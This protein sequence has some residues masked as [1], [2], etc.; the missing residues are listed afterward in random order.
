MLALGVWAGGRGM[1]GGSCFR[2]ALYS[3]LVTSFDNHS[4]PLNLCE[5]TE[6]CAVSASTAHGPENMAITRISVFYA[7][8]ESYAFF[9]AYRFRLMPSPSL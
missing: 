2:F 7:G 6:P 9:F 3:K 5:K 1:V 4:N 8:A